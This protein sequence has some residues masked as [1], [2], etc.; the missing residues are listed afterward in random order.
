MTTT[1][2]LA[3]AMRELIA[4]KDL[5]EG[6]M[7]RSIKASMSKGANPSERY[8]EWNADY[9]RRNPLAW[10]AARVALAS[11]DAAQSASQEDDDGYCDHCGENPCVSRA[12]PAAVA[13]PAEPLRKEHFD[14][15]AFSAALSQSAEW[16]G[17]T[18]K[19]VAAKTGVSET[20]L[21]RMRN[22]GRRPDAAS[23]AALSSWAGINP[24]NYDSRPRKGGL[25][26]TPPPTEPSAEPIRCAG[27]DIPNGCPEYCR[28]AP[29]SPEPSAEVVLPEPAGYRTRYTSEPGMIGHY[30]WTYADQSR[31]R[32]DRPGYDY[33]DLFTAAQVRA[34][35]L[36]DRAARVPLT[37]GQIDR[38]WN[39]MGSFTERYADWRIFARA[40]ER[41]HGITPTAPTQTA[42]KAG[43]KR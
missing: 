34:A 4:L 3:D 39:G 29:A 19:E 32:T 21:S 9:K 6:A 14:V 2:D 31:R 35:I 13:E 17:L 37:D 1:K 10:D 15:A 20:T 41:A 33:E 5:K 42:P 12:A 8:H 36:A 38:T 26:A 30:P 40:I 27:C 43:E 22:E 18:M 11:H 28:C 25:I 16:Q 7:E 23:I 24:A